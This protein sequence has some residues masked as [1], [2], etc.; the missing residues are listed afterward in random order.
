MLG[1]GIA[2]DERAGVGMLRSAAENGMPPAQ[3]ELGSLYLEGRSV[4]KN[5][6][7]RS[8]G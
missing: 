4:P 3:M 8:G 6:G 1:L 2:K 7:R 5:E